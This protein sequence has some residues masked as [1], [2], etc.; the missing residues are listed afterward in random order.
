MIL[1]LLAAQVAA[2][3]TPPASARPVT[4]LD[5]TSAPADVA[6]VQ[7]EHL[8]LATLPDDRLTVNVTVAGQGPFRFL[9]DT[10]ADRTAVSRQLAERLGLPAGRAVRL[11]SVTG[12]SNAR[13]ANVSDMRV[14]SRALPDVIAPLLDAAHVRADGIL[15]TDV[16]RSSMIRF[17]FR[18][19]LLSISSPRRESRR[20]EGDTIVVQARQ[21]AGRLIVTQ[22]E[23]DGQKLIVV[24]DTGSEVT[25]GNSALRAAL[26]RRGILREDRPIELASVTGEKLA[27]TYMSLKKL[28][29]GGLHL[30]DLGIAFADAH[31]FTVMGLTDRPALLLGMN[32]LRAFDSVTIDLAARKLRFSLPDEGDDGDVSIGP[33]RAS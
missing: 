33:A 13:T 23:A 27:A 5:S 26:S 10:G 20:T 17:D 29:I 3:A 28:E 1:F 31:T 8:A 24:L 11:H 32:A 19:G 15:G 21:R 2:P 12:M 30:T 22:A 9:V 18:A 14:A 25:I 7:K 4:T 6:G 16:L